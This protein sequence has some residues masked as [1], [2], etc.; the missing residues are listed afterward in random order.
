[1]DGVNLVVRDTILLAPAG[2]KSLE[3]LGGLYSEM[4]N[5]V[6]VDVYYKSRMDELLKDDRDLFIRYAENDA[7]IPLIHSWFM[8]EYNFN[9]GGLGIPAT[10]S[11]MSARYLRNVWDRNGYSGYQV[12]EYLLSNMGKTMTPKGLVSVGDVGLKIGYYIVNYRGGRNESFMYGCDSE[13][14]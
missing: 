12:S 5:K 9:M 14:H 1:M 7:V 6:D 13:T 2:K 11:G 4:F 10:I 8:E 3:S